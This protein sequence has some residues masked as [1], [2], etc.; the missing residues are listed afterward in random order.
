MSTGLRKAR[1]CSDV[2]QSKDFDFIVQTGFD[3]VSD[4]SSA[5]AVPR[6]SPQELIRYHCAAHKAYYGR[7]R[8]I[9]HVLR[10]YGSC[11]KTPVDYPKPYRLIHSA[12]ATVRGS[13]ESIVGKATHPSNLPDCPGLV[14]AGATLVRLQ[15]SFRAACVLCET[16]MGF[17]VFCL[18]KLILEQIAWAYTV[19]EIEDEW[20]YK[21]KPSKCIYRLKSLYPRVGKIY[22]SI[23]EQAHLDPKKIRDFTETD[24][25]DYLIL[26]RDID[27]CLLGCLYLLQLADMY[28]TCM[29]VIYRRWYT[30]FEFIHKRGSE[31][32]LKLRRKSLAN[33]RM[34]QAKVFPYLDRREDL[35]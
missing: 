28:G 23:N 19:R 8:S 16:R 25:Q 3:V 26:L 9:D 22:G 10:V 33:I 21:V 5:F 32:K 31:P 11:W 29:E 15:T 18:A 27:K 2:F 12:T 30:T 20:P 13:V 14:A 24:A 34:F 6:G 7:Y 4:Q 17:E 35:P 1:N